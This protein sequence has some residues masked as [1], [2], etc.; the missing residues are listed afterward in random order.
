[1]EKTSKKIKTSDYEF[2]CR[3]IAL[4]PLHY[5]KYRNHHFITDDPSLVV[6]IQHYINWYTDATPN[7]YAVKRVKEAYGLLG[8]GSSKN[9]AWKQVYNKFVP[10][11]TEKWHKYEN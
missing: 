8:F 2:L 5:Y 3:L 6:H 9:I 7:K 10:T 1:M 4:T 11:P